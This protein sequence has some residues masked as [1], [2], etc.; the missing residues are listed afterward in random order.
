MIFPELG[1]IVNV[2]VWS[3]VLLSLVLDPESDV[4]LRSRIFGALG[5]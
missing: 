5:A 1:V 3:F 4:V 2:G